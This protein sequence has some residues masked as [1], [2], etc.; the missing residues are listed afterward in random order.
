MISL[1][2]SLEPSN[3]L[4]NIK[5]PYEWFIS[6]DHLPFDLS[7]DNYYTLYEEFLHQLYKLYLETNSTYY[8]FSLKGE[9]IADKGSRVISSNSLKLNKQKLRDIKIEQILQ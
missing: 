2:Y 7:Q 6:Q 5:S 3:H 8:W 1:E 9:L 4:Q